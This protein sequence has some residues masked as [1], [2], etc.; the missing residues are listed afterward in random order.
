[1]KSLLI[2]LVAATAVL[3]VAGDDITGGPALCNA[4]QAQWK[5]PADAHHRL[6]GDGW[7]ILALKQGDDC[8]ELHGIDRRRQRRFAYIDPVTLGIV[9]QIPS[10]D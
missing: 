1:M 3:A 8:Y 6:V 9:R 7:T 10:G 4:T 2:P 5:T